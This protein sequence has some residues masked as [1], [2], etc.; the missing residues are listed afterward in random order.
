MFICDVLAVFTRTPL[1]AGFGYARL[2]NHGSCNLLQV[3]EIRYGVD[4]F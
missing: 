2:L 3:F 1:I 4:I